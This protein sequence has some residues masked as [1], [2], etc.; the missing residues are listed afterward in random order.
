MSAPTSRES[1]PS[2]AAPSTRTMMRSESTE[3]TIPGRLHSTT[4]AR[5]PRRHLLHPGAHVGASARSSGTAWRCH[6]R[7]HQGAGWRRRFPE[8]ESN[9]PPPTQAVWGSRRCTR[10]PPA[11]SARSCPLARVRKIRYDAALLVPAPRWPGRWVYLSSLPR[12]IGTRSGLRTRRL[13]LELSLR[14]TSSASARLTMSP[15]L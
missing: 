3:S 8:T 7:S 9:S 6:V 14:L 2:W 15:T 4:G 1:W 10:S 5:V 12:R 13:F 11:A